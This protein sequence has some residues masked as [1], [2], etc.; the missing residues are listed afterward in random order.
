MGW[1][2]PG[3]Y[4]PPTGGLALRCAISCEN[5]PTITELDSAPACRRPTQRNR[6]HASID[7][8]RRERRT[9]VSGFPGLPAQWRAGATCLNFDLALATASGEANG[10][11]YA[12]EPQPLKGVTMGMTVVAQRR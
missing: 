1:L 3:T 11:A 8:P 10:K 5:Q 4:G 2:F 12:I 9:P 6:R 7:P